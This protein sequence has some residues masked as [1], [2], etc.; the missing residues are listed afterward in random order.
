MKKIRMLMI[1]AVSGLMVLTLSG[2]AGAIGFSY[3]DTSTNASGSGITYQVDITVGTDGGYSGTLTVLGAG[4]ES[5]WDL[6]W[7]AFKLA[8]V[9]L[10]G[11]TNKFLTIDLGSFGRGGGAT[12][13]IAS[14]VPSP[15]RSL[16]LRRGL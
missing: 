6:N 10:D 2:M 16:I 11:Q 14:P 8:G 4:G 5:G 9:Q 3:T 13:A 7:V 15:E 1:I 12:L